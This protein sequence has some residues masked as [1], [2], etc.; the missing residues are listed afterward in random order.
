[1]ALNTLDGPGL[2]VAAVTGASFAVTADCDG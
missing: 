1:M 2:L